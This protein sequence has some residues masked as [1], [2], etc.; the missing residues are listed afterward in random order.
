MFERFKNLF[1]TETKSTLANPSPELI[2]LFGSISSASGVAVTPESA[3]R[4]PTVYASVKVIGESVAQ[5]PLHL[6]RRMTDGGKERAVDH[7]LA[8]LLNGQANDW[9]S[10]FEFR[11]YMQTALCLYGNAF[12]FINRTGGKITEL[13]P[14][15]SPSVT[16]EVDAVTMEPSYKVSSSDGRQRVYDRSEIFHL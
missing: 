10:A 6:Y 1:R 16:V 14:I 3:M 5:L 7:P 4:C 12:A 11:L 15:P 9:T 8:E 13:I 2:A